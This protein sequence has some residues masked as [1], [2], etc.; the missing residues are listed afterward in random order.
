MWSSKNQNEKISFP[1]DPKRIYLSW[2]NKT[3]NMKPPSLCAASHKFSFQRPPGY[4]PTWALLGSS[5]KNSPSY[6][7]TW[8]LFPT[9]P[10]VQRPLCIGH[11]DSSFLILYY[12]PPAYPLWP[13]AKD[14]IARMTS[15]ITSVTLRILHSSPPAHFAL[16]HIHIAL[17]SITTGPL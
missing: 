17:S 14:A 2:Q 13:N 4:I 3:S 10:K 8:F 16:N 6:H 11:L 7:T 5:P 12:W 1:M 15:A 9:I